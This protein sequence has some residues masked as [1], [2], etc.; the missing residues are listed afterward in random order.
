MTEWDSPVQ[1]IYWPD[2]G[3]GAEERPSMTLREAIRAARAVTGER[4]AWIVTASGHILRPGEV[5]RL[6]AALDEAPPAR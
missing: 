6:A 2:G 3:E 4:R 5:A 1:L